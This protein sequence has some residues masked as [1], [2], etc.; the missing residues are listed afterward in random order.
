LPFN[1]QR[2]ERE[3]GSPA[4][5]ALLRQSLWCEPVVGRYSRVAAMHE[6]QPVP[7]PEE[8]R[9]AA[10]AGALRPTSNRAA[11]IVIKFI[12]GRTSWNAIRRLPQPTRARGFPFLSRS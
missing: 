11:L 4:G 12:R 9:P 7:V 10:P 6:N 8:Q 1:A 5:Y 3:G 2:R